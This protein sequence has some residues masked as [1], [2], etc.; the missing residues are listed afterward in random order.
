MDEGVVWSRVLYRDGQAVQG[1]AYLWSQDESGE[2]FF[3]FGNE[4]GYPPG[5]YE[6]R[7][8]LGDHE[9]SRFD[10]TVLS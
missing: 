1:Q 4:A 9:V 8:Y 6:V 3:F 10:F 5:E 2:S 7:I